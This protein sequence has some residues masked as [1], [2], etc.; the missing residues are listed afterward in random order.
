MV[1]F[2]FIRPL[3]IRQK[4]RLGQKADGGYVVYAGALSDIDL[5]VSYGVGWEV[6][7]EEDFNSLTK[8][9]ALM[10]DPTL[11]GRYIMKKKVL[12]RLLVHF[13]LG[14]LVRY[15]KF[16][17]FI[18]RKKREL[19]G[20]NILFVNE[21]IGVGRTTG[22]DTL[23]NHLQRFGLEDKRILLKMDIEGG[24]YEIL[25]REEFHLRIERNVTQMIIE[26]HDLKNRL[27]RFKQVIQRLKQTY[28]VVHV[29]GNNCGDTF[30]V[31]PDTELCG[32]PVPVPDTLEIT[33]VRKDKIAEADILF[34]KMGYPVN[35]LD[36]P[37]NPRRAD[38]PLYFV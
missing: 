36:Y 10:F 11:M 34:E 29:H 5:L 24:E 14:Q 21:G 4:I 28:E 15:C 2:S 25:S 37:N 7:F 27:H 33:L 3:S 26:F 18:W 1:N 17:L 16:V 31:Y 23:Q 22:Y 9:G 20:R 6:S 32:E 30:S 35:G 38:Y 13:R 8:K 19:A 12:R